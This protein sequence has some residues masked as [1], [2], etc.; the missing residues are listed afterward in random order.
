MVLYPQASLLI[1]ALSS[2]IDTAI[3]E[4]INGSDIGTIAINSL[5]SAFLGAASGADSSDFT[6]AQ[7][8][9]IDMFDAKK[10]SKSID[11]RPKI[12]KEADKT[13]QKNRKKLKKSSFRGLIDD[14][15]YEF[16]KFISHGWTELQLG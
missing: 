10:T 5:F 2:G 6:K 3:Y 7:K 9:L 8:N 14:F 4:I 11:V 15:I 16:L 13:Y 12:R 1:C